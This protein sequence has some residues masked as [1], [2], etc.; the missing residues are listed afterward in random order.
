MISVADSPRVNEGPSQ[1]EDVLLNH[2]LAVRLILERM[3]EAIR[4]GDET[5]RVPDVDDLWE[6][7]APR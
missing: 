2:A 1:A 6:I 7:P 4:H 5:S 3:D